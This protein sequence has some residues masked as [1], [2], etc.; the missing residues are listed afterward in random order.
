[1]SNWRDKIHEII[2]EADTKE[3]KAFDVALLI[4]IILSVLVVTL[5]SVKSYNQKYGEYFTI[6]EWTFTGLFVIEYIL[7]IIC[8]KK[9]IHYIFSFL[10]IIDLLSVLPNFI[11]L[12]FIQSHS[13]II[14]RT[15]R[16]LRVFRIF[17]L[18]KFIGEAKKLIDALRASRHKIIVF[19]VFILAITVLMGTFMYLVEGEENGFTN[20]PRS[21]YW[22]IVTLTTV[23]YGDIAPQTVLGQTIASI[24]MIMGYGVIAVPTGI[25][26]VQIAKNTKEYANTISCSFCGDE[27]HENNANYCKNCGNKL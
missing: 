27:G 8:L 21:M 1:M 13:L 22:A 5:E 23:G 4:V 18:V 15:L 12:F 3:G 16:L 7:R 6:L 2:F 9:P 20:I 25:V 11:G 26:S 14:L 24:I 17:K 19:I 10:G